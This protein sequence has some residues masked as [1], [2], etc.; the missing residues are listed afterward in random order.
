MPWVKKIKSDKKQAFS[1]KK[2][3]QKQFIK[4]KKSQNYFLN[5]ILLH[6]NCSVHVCVVYQYLF[7]KVSF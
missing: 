7:P 5:V 3:D 2:S 6:V 4:P 1:S